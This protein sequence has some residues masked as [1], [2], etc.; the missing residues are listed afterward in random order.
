[1]IGASQEIALLLFF[2]WT[3][4][5]LTVDVVAVGLVSAMILIFKFWN[6]SFKFEFQGY[7]SKEK[8]CE[9]VSRV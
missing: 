7:N 2:G 6:E 4:V 9:L 5:A 8:N 3:D 1:M